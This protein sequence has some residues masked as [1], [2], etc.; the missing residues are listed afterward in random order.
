MQ[1]N[2]GQLSV[3]DKAIVSGFAAGEKKYRAKLLAMGLTKGIEL[4]L[5]RVAPLGDPLE[6][7]VR[8]FS[9][10][11]RKAEAAAVLVERN[12]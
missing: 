6:I 3:G 12:G 1:V 4:E 8:G 9:L 7:S 2:L 10:S 11:L 5:T